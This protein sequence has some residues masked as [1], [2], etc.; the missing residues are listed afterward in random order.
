VL[1]D[2]FDDFVVGSAH[3]VECVAYA[4][5]LLKARKAVVLAADYGVRNLV[6][7]VECQSL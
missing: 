1:C 3:F 4:A 2:D 5:E 6:L 7:E